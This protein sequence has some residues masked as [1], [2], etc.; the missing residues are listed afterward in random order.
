MSA[1]VAA[2]ALGVAQALRWRVRQVTQELWSDR[3]PLTGLA[4][5]RTGDIAVQSL[6]AQQPRSASIPLFR[7]P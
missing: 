7:F 2:A 5:E 4:D 6:L 1:A 3:V